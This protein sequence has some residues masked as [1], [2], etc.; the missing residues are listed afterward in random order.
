MNWEYPIFAVIIVVGFAVQQR[1]MY[2]RLQEFPPGDQVVQNSTFR[3]F[4]CMWF[5]IIFILIMG[6]FHVEHKETAEKERIWTSFDWITPTLAYEMQHH[7]HKLIQQE[8]TMDDPHYGKL[9]EIMVQWMRLNPHIQSVYTMKKSTDGLVCFWLAPETDYDGNG[10]IE[11]PKEES[12]PI[13]T[14]YEEV[15]PEIEEA[16]QGQYSVQTEPT[17]DYWGSS[18]S[19]FMPIYDGSGEV[20]AVLGIDFSG[21]LWY[22]ALK[23]AR[24]ESIALLFALLVF[25]DV[26]YLILFYSRVERLRMRQLADERIKSW[27]ELQQAKEAA[28]AANRVKGEFLANMSHE[29]RTPMNAILGMTTVLL[30][31][32]LN[33]EQRDL[34]GTVHESATALLTIINDTLDYSK[35][36]AGKMTLENLEF[37]LRA[38]VE[39]TAELVA[40]TARGK[41]LPVMTYVD[42]K[43]PRLLWGDP[44]RIRQILLN[45]VG[46]AVKFTRQGEVSLRAILQERTND[47]IIIRFTI[48]DTGIGIRDEA[49]KN[50]FRPFTQADNSM[51]RKY[52]GTGLG[53]SIVKR[54]VTLMKG[55]IGVESIWGSGSTFWFTA[56]FAFSQSSEEMPQYGPIRGADQYKAILITDSILT[57]DIILRYL[58]VMGVNTTGVYNCDELVSVLSE[59]NE[60][61]AVRQLLIID[62]DSSCA[63]NMD[64]IQLIKSSII[65]SKCPCI[66]LGIHEKEQKKEWGCVSY[67]IKPIKFKQLYNCIEVLLLNKTDGCQEA[68]A[69]MTDEERLCTCTETVSAGGKIL[70]VEDN[71]ANQKLALLLLDKLGYNA[72]AV[73]NGREAVDAVLKGHYAAVLMDCQMPEMDGFEAT[74][75]IRTALMNKELHMPII[76]MTANA[77]E[78]DREKCLLAGMDDYISKPFRIETLKMVLGRWITP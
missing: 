5:M 23:Q 1:W 24:I 4:A 58:Q 35:I 7:S 49:L 60:L 72:E 10:V 25:L 38:V 70:L 21:E 54:L 27:E 8:A 15:I 71:R 31:T 36:E 78:G 3:F 50:L 66:T 46:N 47:R 65:F 13:G 37:N 18:I 76:A 33:Y 69:T 56:S 29:I 41:G 14:V 43:I 77:M 64:I 6:F 63:Q 55:E 22:E 30:E 45:L 9:M 74:T 34:A 44:G 28:E 32:P 42:P 57:A 40:W 11:G 73:G 61:S 16:F 48:M 68:A 52:G 51:A 2:V 20:N 62:S 59:K 19:A 75:Q 53:L 12:V 39:G 17:V 26:P 67:L